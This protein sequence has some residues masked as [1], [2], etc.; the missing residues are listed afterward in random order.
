MRQAA[1]L[2][3]L[4]RDFYTDLGYTIQHV[5][6]WIDR[7]KQRIDF[8]GFADW[9]AVG[10]GSIIAVQSTSHEHRAD[11]YRKILDAPLARVWLDNGGRI[12]LITWRKRPVRVMGK[13]WTETREELGK[14][15]FA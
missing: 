3:R 9:I 5:E 11:H 4:T 15:H 10:H 8:F 12:E 6:K 13:L 2:N 1:A 14:S 7:T